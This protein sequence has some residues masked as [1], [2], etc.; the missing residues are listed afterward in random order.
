MTC[1]EMPAESGRATIQGVR[2]LS[3]PRRYGGD[4]RKYSLPVQKGR[5]MG[6]ES[7]S[8]ADDALYGDAGDPFPIE[9]AWRYWTHA[10]RVVPTKAKQFR[11]KKVSLVRFYATHFCV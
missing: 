5:G 7:E 1:H 9:Q 8:D 4:Y 6:S 11:G 3:I 10:D 2:A